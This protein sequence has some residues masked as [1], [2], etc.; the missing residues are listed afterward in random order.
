[1]TPADWTRRSVLA[2]GAALPGATHGASP[3][4]SAGIRPSDLRVEWLSAPLGVDTPRPRFGWTLEGAAPAR[5]LVQSALRVV[6]AEDAADAAAGRGTIWDS[7]R[8]ESAALRIRP[9]RELPLAPH[10]RYAWAVAVWDGAGR[11]TLSAPQTFV[12]GLLDP[13]RWEARWIAAEPDGPQ[14]ETVPPA[15]R[16]PTQA[17]GT[18]MPLFRRAFRLEKPVRAA[19]LSIAGLGQYEAMINGRKVGDALI[20]PGWTDYRKTVLYDTYDVAGLLGPG[21]NV[22][23]VMLG[24]GMYNVEGVKGRYTKFIGSFGQPKLIARLTLDFADATRAAIVSDGLWTARPGPIV[25]SS[26]YGGEDHDARREPQGWLT[27][28]GGAGWTPALEVDGPGG[29]LKASGVPPV[30]LDR[31]LKPVAVSEPAPGVFVYDLGENFAG[32]PSIAVRGPAG[33]VVKLLP[34]ELLDEHGRVTQRSANGRPGFETSFS[35]TLAGRD[36]ERWAPRFSYY[37]FRYVEVTG[38]APAGRA[39]PG[40]PVL[41]A[42]EGEFLHADL[43]RA[44]VF[45]ASDVLLARTHRLIDQAVLSNMYSVLTDCPHR[46][47]LGWLEQ[48][49]LNAATVLYNR[50]ALTLYEKMIGDI[51]D[52]QHPDGLTPEIAPEYLSFVLPGGDTRFLDSPEWGAAVVLSPWAAYRF[53]GDPAVLEAGYPAMR[54]YMAYLAGK[55]RDGILDYGL[56]DWYDVGPARPGPAQLTSRAL[57][58]T[59]IYFEMLAA[60]SRIAPLVGAPALE[61]ERWRARASAVKAAFNAR[62]F[63]PATSRYDRD[64]QTASA[65]PLALGLVPDGHERAVLA[66]LVAAVRARDNH[67][68]AGDVGFHYVV[69]ALTRYGRS[70]VLYDMLSRTDAP[71][72]GAQLA[73]G[74]TALTEAWDADP[75]ASQNHFMLGHAELWLYGGLA[76]IRI[77]MAAAPDRRI[78]IDPQPV[79]EVAWAAARYRSA[80][81]EV[82]SDWRREGGR[83]RLRVRVPAGATATVRLPTAEARAVRESGRPLALAPGVRGAGLAGGR[84]AAVVGSGDYL[85]EAPLT[86]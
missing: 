30:R 27:A 41:A 58:A 39:A 18:V 67:V 20:A 85:F 13:G 21:D 81:G 52:S 44:G 69:E 56:G 37:G 73:R 65:M 12:T 62:L 15:I 16:K 32:R 51:V 55:A 86:A 71:S 22:L 3:G 35:Y 43:P 28:G 19:T 2:A 59:A 79:G 17:Q 25:F 48:T 29:R 26:I 80:L 36:E 60:L 77:D 74:A 6:V 40:V 50:D 46:E 57:T 47:K 53:Y 76:G 84:V 11:M 66:R 31:T 24:D 7:G 82:V 49:H 83:L 63:D 42:L 68:S 10:R 75:R 9:P 4:F 61:A 54:A 78:V 33:A 45:D 72:Y 8:I 38:A 64:S 23:G 1:M 34:G 14:D 5:G 70:D